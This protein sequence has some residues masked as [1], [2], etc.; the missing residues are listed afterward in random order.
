MVADDDSS[1]ERGPSALVRACGLVLVACAALPITP[2]GRSFLALLRGEFG[3]GL[4][5]GVLMLCGFGSPF[6]F[7]LATAIS[8]SAWGRRLGVELVR[9]PV[10]MM[11]GQLLLV[12]F[13]TWRAGRGV[14]AL[15]LFGFA[16]VAA[17]AYVTGA[18]VRGRATSRTVDAIHWGAVVVTAVAAWCEL[19][20][21]GGIAMGWG[22][23]VIVATAFALAWTTRPST[24][25]VA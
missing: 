11:H 14:A 5:D 18:R 19:Q 16:V 25:A 2:D 10:G 13:V 22:L 21:V 23:H 8:G 3:R 12:A 17:Y 24:R 1:D 4:L 6:L 15:G 9:T 20:R 7:G